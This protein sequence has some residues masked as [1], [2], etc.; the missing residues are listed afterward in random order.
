MLDHIH[1]YNDHKINNF[2]EPIFSFVPSIGISEI[3]KIS[4]NNYTVSSL[5]ARSLYFFEI[6]ND[7]I[8]NL[9]KVEI[10]ERIRDIKFYT[11]NLYLFL[12]TT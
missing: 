3:T 12:P 6:G 10:F 4:D 1:H 8:I 7:K 2:I 5:G 9:D 11:G